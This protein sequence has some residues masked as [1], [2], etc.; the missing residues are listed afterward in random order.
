M[1]IELLRTYAWCDALRGMRNPKNSWDRGDSK[2]TFDPE[3]G[4][5]T[6]VTIGPNDEKLISAL[7][8]GG[9]VHRKFMRQIFVTMDITAPAYWWAE[10]DTYKVATTRNSC[11]VQ[12][13]GASRDFV[14]D[15]FTIDNIEFE[16]LELL[17][18]EDKN[19]FN[20]VINTMNSL[21]QKYVETKDYKYFRLLR[22]LMPMGYNYKATWSGSYETL[23]NIYEW[24]HNH[25][26][27][28]WHVFCDE[29]IKNAP[30]FNKLVE[31]A[32]SKN[33]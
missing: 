13:K 16:N 21:R 6:N 27:S 20:N 22:Q 24:R 1:K 28:E 30:Y 29:I 9:M 2:I 5:A 4:C 25:K 7:D 11:S 14:Y 19:S 18:E 12:H 31:F 26:L 8:H 23:M 33:T 10:M 3:S 17:S 15:D 32:F